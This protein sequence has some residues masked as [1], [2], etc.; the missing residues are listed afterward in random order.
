M[1]QC[2]LPE[3]RHVKSKVTHSWVAKT[4]KSDELL[5]IF[6]SMIALPLIYYRVSE[7]A[8]MNFNA[9]KSDGSKIRDAGKEVV[10]DDIW[11]DLQYLFLR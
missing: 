8:R 9:N 2:V 1:G 4:A 10:M 11:L 3:K 5:V 7:T 6:C